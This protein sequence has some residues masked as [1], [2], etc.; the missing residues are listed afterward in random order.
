[1]CYYFAGFPKTAPVKAYQKF[2]RDQLV[3]RS[4]PLYDGSNVTVK[5]F[6]RSQQC[7]GTSLKSQCKECH[8]ILKTANKLHRW[9][10]ARRERRKDQPLKRVDKKASRS[11]LVATLTNARKRYA[12]NDLIYNE[13]CEKCTS[14]SSKLRVVTLVEK[15]V[16]LHVKKSWSCEKDLD[17]HIICL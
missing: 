2:H 7:T 13:V 6:F 17:P 3:C 14:D 10:I 11:R 1:M 4:I 8:G 12:I 9:K 5:E 15:K 16:V